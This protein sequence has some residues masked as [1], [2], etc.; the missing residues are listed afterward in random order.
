[1]RAA[2]ANMDIKLSLLIDE[3]LPQGECSFITASPSCGKTTLALQATFHLTTGTPCFG[4]LDVPRAV[5]VV[6]VAFETSVRQFV[7]KRRRLADAVPYNPDLLWFDPYWSGINVKMEQ[8]TKDFIKHI[9]GLTPKPEAIVIDPAYKTVVGGLSKDEEGN[10]F[11]RFLGKLQAET[12]AASL[13]MH[14]THREKWEA[15]KVVI[16]KNPSFGSQWLIAHPSIMWNVTKWEH[17][18]KWTISKDRES[19]CRQEMTLHYDAITGASWAPTEV[20][21]SG[22]VAKAVAYLKACP[23]GFEAPTQEVAHKIGCSVGSLRNRISDPALTSIVE[24]VR[25]EGRPT[26]WKVLPRTAI[27]GTPHTNGATK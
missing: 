13:V 14:H 25:K 1:M 19:I 10:A 8:D 20:N 26:V 16:E 4:L 6:Y 3:L 5:P 9:N 24:F 17:G 18:T 12:G 23:V 27:H 7:E 2:V 15:G 21:E 22:V 11:T